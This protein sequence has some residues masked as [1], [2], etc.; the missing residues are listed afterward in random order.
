[1]ASVIH[2]GHMSNT[3]TDAIVFWITA[4]GG[5]IALLLPRFA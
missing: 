1:M 5:L 4:F 2:G 3:Q